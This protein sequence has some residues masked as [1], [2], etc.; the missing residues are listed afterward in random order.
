[1]LQQAIVYCV[2]PPD[3]SPQEE[4]RL[5]DRLKRW[6]VDAPVAFV[7]AAL[8]PRALRSKLETAKLDVD[9]VGV[10]PGGDA[11]DRLTLAILARQG[12]A[13]SKPAPRD[14]RVVAI[15]P[16]FNEGDIIAATLKD[17]IQ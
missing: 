3:A 5:L 7:A 14:F 9:F 6:M 1:S 8:E 10:V 16:A 13:P 12:T 11:R 15:V 17:L 4:A 2:W